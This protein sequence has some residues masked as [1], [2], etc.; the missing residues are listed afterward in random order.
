MLHHIFV[1]VCTNLTPSFIDD[2]SQI[3]VKVLAYPQNSS[4][5]QYC[6]WMLT[7]WKPVYE[8]KMKFLA[9]LAILRLPLAP[10]E[11]NNSE[12]LLEYFSVIRRK[13]K[14]MKSKIDQYS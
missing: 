7:V 4:T 8:C 9:S 11:T 5:V 3:A 13:N 1:N 14:L 10:F 6:N 2:G 12:I